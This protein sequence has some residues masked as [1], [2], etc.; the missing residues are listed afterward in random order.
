M[1]LNSLS[2]LKLSKILLISFAWVIT[3][4]GVSSAS[5]ISEECRNE[6]QVL[7]EEPN[8]AISQ[9]IIFEDYTAS[10]NDVCDLG[11]GSV[12]C[13]VAFEG[14]ERTYRALCAGQGGQVYKRPVLLT[15]A[16]GAVEYDLGY[17]PTCVGSSCNVSAVE[18]GDVIT[19]Q[20]QIF[21]DN[22]TGFGC[23]A[24]ASA[25]VGDHQFFIHSGF[26]LAASM[27]LFSLIG[28]SALF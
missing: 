28:I 5:E 6:T 2:S 16:F 11:L 27:L 15:C 9:K 21:L 22:L 18:P 25:A 10:F 7:L 14:D 1:F 20:V 13:S 17:I 3:T 8:L 23:A 12:D 19:D 24:D 4:T 26:F